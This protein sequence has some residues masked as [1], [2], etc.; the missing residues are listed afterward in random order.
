MSETPLFQ[1]PHVAPTQANKELTIN[2][3]FNKLEAALANR[4]RI[5][6]TGSPQAD[7]YIF[8]D[9]EWNAYWLYEFGAHDDEKD[10]VIP[11]DR[12]R[13]FVVANAGSHDLHVVIDGITPGPGTQIDV[14]PG[15][16][17]YI[18]AMGDKLYAMSEGAGGIGATFSLELQQGTTP[19]SAPGFSN[20][21]TEIIRFLS[22]DF[23][24]SVHSSIV[25]VS[26][27]ASLKEAAERTDVALFLPGE[28]LDE[29]YLA[30]IAFASD[31]WFKNE[32]A[33]VIACRVAPTNEVV[34]EVM[35]QI[36][37]DSPE[38]LAAIIT[39]PAST[40]IGSI[41]FEDPEIVCLAGSILSIVGPAAMDATC[42]DISVTL[43]G[44][45]NGA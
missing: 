10:I 20:T 30:R 35:H 3:G 34:L 44:V 40:Y 6:F 17:A 29:T 38:T 21:G 31:T 8:T 24:L 15:A 14:E 33:C 36:D 32:A 1:I 9:T 23:D 11:A 2:T 39:I 25:L 4:I 28:P 19:P 16:A 5:N 22:G 7:E 12:Q 13:P 41:A 27:A 37:G 26:L 45:K 42:A 18:Y 43:K